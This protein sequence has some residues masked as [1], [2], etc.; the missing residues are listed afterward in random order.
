MG[1]HSY[2]F[3]ECPECKKTTVHSVYRE[4][5]RPIILWCQSC[6]RVREGSATRKT[7][8]PGMEDFIK[9]LRAKC[10]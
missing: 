7:D 9:I 5:G 10:F 8:Y 1:E 4:P 3:L 2:R 6:F